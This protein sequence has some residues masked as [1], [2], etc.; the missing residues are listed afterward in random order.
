MHVRLRYVAP[1]QRAPVRIQVLNQQSSPK[2]IVHH[3]VF[4]QADT[5]LFAVVRDVSSSRLIQASSIA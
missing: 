2:Y 3:N 1:I 4:G 5:C